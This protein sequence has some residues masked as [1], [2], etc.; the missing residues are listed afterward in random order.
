MELQED[1]LM[2]RVLKRIFN[3]KH[4]TINP[5]FYSHQLAT[6]SHHKTEQKKT[7]SNP[8]ASL[9]Y[10]RLPAC[11]HRAQKHWPTAT[12]H[13]NFFLS[14][15]YNFMQSR[16][17]SK[18]K[19]KKIPAHRVGIHKFHLRVNSNCIFGALWFIGC[20]AICERDGNLKI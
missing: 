12:K 9:Y 19:Y 13:R 20:A 1:D 5:N 3:F 15:R 8:P 14:L 2:G 16:I 17:C 6:N 10:L 18:R 11:K 4:R 7:F